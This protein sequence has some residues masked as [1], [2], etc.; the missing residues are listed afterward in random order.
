[1]NRALLLLQC[2]V[3]LLVAV[4]LV[5]VHRLRSSVE[6][7]LSAARL[8]PGGA[9]APPSRD[10]AR[11]LEELRAACDEFLSNPQDPVEQRIAEKR[12]DAAVTALKAL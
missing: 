10:P 12:M 6:A 2:L 11:L 4:C 8:Q 3:L 5:Q 9:S 7:A 1:M